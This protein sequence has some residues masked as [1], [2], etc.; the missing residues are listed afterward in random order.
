MDKSQVVISVNSLEK[1]YRGSKVLRGIHFTVTKGSIF[2]LLFYP[3]FYGASV[4]LLRR[5]P[6]L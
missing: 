2:A 3:L 6:G 1:S 5:M 4:Y